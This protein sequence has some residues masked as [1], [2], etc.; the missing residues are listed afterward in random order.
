[1]ATKFCKLLIR[2][3]LSLRP[4]MVHNVQGLFRGHC[5]GDGFWPTS[6]VATE[7]VYRGMGFPWPIANVNSFSFQ[8]PFI[9]SL[10]QLQ[11]NMKTAKTEDE[12][13]FRQTKGPCHHRLEENKSVPNGMYHDRKENIVWPEAFAKEYIIAHNVYPSLEFYNYVMRR[14]K[15]SFWVVENN[16]SIGHNC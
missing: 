2:R 14:T 10:L 15:H 7:D 16:M 8:A 4:D 5:R 6:K 13:S 12:F 9:E 11:N 3:E 1:M